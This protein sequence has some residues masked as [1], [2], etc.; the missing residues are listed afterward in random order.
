MN[1]LEC[2]KLEKK[3]RIQ[4]SDH[5]FELRKLAEDKSTEKALYEINIQKEVRRWQERYHKEKQDH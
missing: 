2:V 4:L 3:L 1:C 5:E